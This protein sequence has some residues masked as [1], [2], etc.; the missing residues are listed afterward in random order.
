MPRFAANLAYL[1]T[2][3]PLIER[4]AAAAAAGFAAVEL[5]FP[6]D[7]PAGA[8]KAEIDR[9]GLTQLGINT[10]FGREGEF[11]L[12]AV[13]GRE[14]DFDRPFGQALDHVVASGGRAIHCLAGKVA[15]EQRPA[16]EQVFIANLER[17]ADLASEKNITLLIEP[18]NPRDRPDYFLTRVEHAADIV[19]KVGRA[20]VRIQF[21]FYHV[22]I[23]GGDLIRRKSTRLNSSHLGI[24]YAVFCLK[25]KK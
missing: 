21:D 22:Q 7:H 25:K 8:V 15:P 23:V 14:R 4:F 18:I 24:S 13:P 20:N 11:G 2:E 19:A 6:Y 3:R 16:G 1:F 17:A 12:A 9:H 10:P 5:Q